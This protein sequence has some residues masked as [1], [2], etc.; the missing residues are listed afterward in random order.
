[1]IKSLFFE[2]IIWAESI[3]SSIP[4]RVGTNI[5]SIWFKYRWKEKQKISNNFNHRMNE[6]C[7]INDFHGGGVYP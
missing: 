7:L 6:I 3:L 5:R 4:G 1:M 2:I